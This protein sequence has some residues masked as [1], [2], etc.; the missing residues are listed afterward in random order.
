MRTKPPLLSAVLLRSGVFLL[1]ML[2]V[3]VAKCDQLGRDPLLVAGEQA[4]IGLYGLDNILL[5]PGSLVALHVR[6]PLFEGIGDSPEDAL[7]KGVLTARQFT[8]L[9]KADSTMKVLPDHT[10]VISNAPGANLL[11]NVCLK[12]T[13]GIQVYHI[14][15]TYGYRIILKCDGLPKDSFRAKFI[16]ADKPNPRILEVFYCDG[17]K[18]GFMFRFT[19]IDQ[20]ARETPAR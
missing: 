18:A 5:A 20:A 4:I 3:S 1:V 14:W 19:N 16:N 17:D 15:E 11:T 2:V 9:Q 12:G 8:T 13:W 6:H 7:K 10:F